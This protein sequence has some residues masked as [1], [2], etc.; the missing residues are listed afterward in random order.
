[1]YF[2]SASKELRLLLT[3]AV[4]QQLR[5]DFEE[6]TALCLKV[7]K[8]DCKE[9]R[10]ATELIWRYKGLSG[11]DMATLG[12]LGAVALLMYMRRRAR[13][14]VTKQGAA[15][16]AGNFEQDGFFYKLETH[17]FENERIFLEQLRDT[18]DPMAQCA[19]WNPSDLEYPFLIS[20]CL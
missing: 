12:T 17:R 13:K 19:P 4:Q 18:G 2:S 14:P 7:G 3:P 10:E 1:M 9:L 11:A 15:G 8:R 5:A 16:H 20:I 6:A